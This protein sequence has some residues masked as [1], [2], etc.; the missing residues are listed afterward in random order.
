MSL[1][2]ANIR[3]RVRAKLRDNDTRNDLD[4]VEIDQ[5][6]AESYLENAAR[7]PAPEYYT[8]NAFT[9]AANAETFSLPTTLLTG[10]ISPLQY[11][12]PVRIQLASDATFLTRVSRDEM[13]SL[14]SGETVTVGRAR[15]SR[16]LVF[17]GQDQEQS[18][19]CWPRSK[20]AEVCNLWRSLVGDDIRDA[21]SDV[22]QA[23][24]FFSRTGSAGLVLHVAA[25]LAA[26]MTPERLAARGLNASVVSLWLK[27]ADAAFRRDAGRHH[28]VASVKRPV[29]SW[30][31]GRTWRR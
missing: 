4:V 13:D 23:A 24:I 22:D 21:T 29:P 11:R 12:G 31:G 10:R 9:I 14:R 1:T 7:L 28:D 20:D 15:P 6:I 8:A 27:D 30:P 17:E 5:Q 18:G 26:A 16:F 3:S 2:V 19:Y 25:R